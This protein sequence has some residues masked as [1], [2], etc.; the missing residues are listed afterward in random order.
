MYIILMLCKPARMRLP[1]HYFFVGGFWSKKVALK[2][3]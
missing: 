1:E 2:Q 3:A